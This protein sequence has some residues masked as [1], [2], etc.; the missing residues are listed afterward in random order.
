ML[1]DHQSLG[2]QRNKLPI[3]EDTVAVHIP[4]IHNRFSYTVA[5]QR[6]STEKTLG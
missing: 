4:C 5:V 6:S 3:S 1:H 2:P